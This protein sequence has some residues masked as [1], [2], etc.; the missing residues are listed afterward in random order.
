[1]NLSQNSQPA[2]G[3]IPPEEK[4]LLTTGA[5]YWS[6]HE[7]PELG[8]PRHPDVGRSARPPRAGRRQPRPPRLGPQPAGYLLPAGRDPRLVVG[9]ATH[10][11]RRRGAGS[12]GPRARAWMWCWAPGSRSSAARCAAGTSS[13]TARTRCS[14]AGWPARWSRACSRRASRACL[15]HFAVNTQ[16]TDRL[17]VS[18]DVDERTLREIYLRAF[19]IAVREGQPLDRHERL[20]PDQRRLRQREPLAAHRRPARRVGLR[21]YRGLRL[22]CRARSRRGGRCGTRPAHARATRRSA[23]ARRAR[24]RD[25][26]RSGGRPRGRATAAPGRAAR[27][28]PQRRRPV[29]DFDAHHQLARRAAA[30]SAVLL[31][32]DR[33]TA[34]DRPGRQSARSR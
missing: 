18:A 34:A 27:R 16:E 14:P 19:E 33:G 7:V 32:N 30:E 4:A 20:Q 1:M 23:G 12:G 25:A 15:K 11:Q 28:T 24:E 6:T 3:D 5:D 9:P 26:R 2:T 29:V 13:T 10:P 8:L 31:H 17:R 21:R 22:G